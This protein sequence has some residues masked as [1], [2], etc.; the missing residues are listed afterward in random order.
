[1]RKTAFILTCLACSVHGRRAQATHPKVRSSLKAGSQKSL[2]ALDT[3]LHPN[4]V[5]AANCANEQGCATENVSIFNR[6]AALLLALNPAGAF[7]SVSPPGRFAQGISRHV[8][9]NRP[10]ALPRLQEYQESPLFSDR[11]LLR[12]LAMEAEEKSMPNRKYRLVIASAIAIIAG[13]EALLCLGLCFNLEL[14]QDFSDIVLWNSPLATLVL[15]LGFGAVSIISN[16][17]EFKIKE[18]N[19]RDIMDMYRVKKLEEKMIADQKARRAKKEAMEKKRMAANEPT[20]GGGFAPV[21]VKAVA[22]K[23]KE[24]VEEEVEE[25]PENDFFNTAPRVQSVN[26]DVL[27]DLA[28]FTLNTMSK[29]VAPALFEEANNM[30]KASALTLNSKL[31][32]MGVLKPIGGNRTMAIDDNVKEPAV[33]PSD[34]LSALMG[35][36]G[37]QDDGLNALVAES[38]KVSQ[39]KDEDEQRREILSELKAARGGNKKRKAKKKKTGKK[40]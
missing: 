8:G 12:E 24:E 5:V 9:L 21:E 35:G 32:D 36:A 18:D 6:F 25:V 15:C 16:K 10:R 1:M 19:I 11:E 17:Q 22:V 20:G 30:A 3:V 14:V 31:E 28:N 37:N 7:N 23:E 27:A 2:T 34:P 39:K 4:S 38:E 40:R 29:K 13:G 26:R 33:D